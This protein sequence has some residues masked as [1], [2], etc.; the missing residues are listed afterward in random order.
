MIY[1]LERRQRIPPPLEDVFAF[2]TEPGNLA[3]ITPPWLRFRIIGTSGEEMR[4]GLRIEYRI[5][6]LGLP[7]RWVSEITA[8]EPP[9]RFVDEQV[10]GPYRV[11]RHEHRFLDLDG[12]TEVYDRVRYALPL[13][14]VGR[15]V[16]RLL[17]RRQLRAVFD[18]RQEAIRRLLG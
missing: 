5:A 14:V 3:A 15:L 7:Q 10:R 9:H 1:I 17:V 11:W 4:Q 12:V 8:W 2:F 18:Y 13:G 16:H 6:P